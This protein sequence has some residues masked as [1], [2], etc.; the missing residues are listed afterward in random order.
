MEEELVDELAKEGQIEG[1][2]KQSNG[3]DD[4]RNTS[5]QQDEE[6]QEDAAFY[7]APEEPL[8]PLPRPLHELATKLSFSVAS[9]SNLLVTASKDET[10]EVLLDNEVC[11]L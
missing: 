11:R 1:D 8:A 3:D 5:D 6:E 10:R 9:K 2:N 7:D 4:Y